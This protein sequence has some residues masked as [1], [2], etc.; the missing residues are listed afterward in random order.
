M[1]FFTERNFMW[2]NTFVGIMLPVFLFLS[3]SKITGDF[4]FK[5]NKEDKY[6]KTAEAPE[7]NIRENID[8][9]YVLN[10]P[11]PQKKFGVYVMKKELVWID[12]SRNTV[13]MEGENT[14]IYGK[15]NNLEE[16]AYKILISYSSEVI[17]EQYF[18]IYKDDDDTDDSD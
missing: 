8:W 1:I 3:C 7:F 12:I 15:I 18:S 2:K 10:K 14:I 13:T 9:V 11:Q 6:R 5:Q 16:G 17:G 4:A